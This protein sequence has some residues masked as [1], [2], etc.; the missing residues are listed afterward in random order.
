M[1][2][3]IDPATKTGWCNGFSSGVEDFS[4]KN[5]DM[6]DR[7]IRFREWLEN[8]LIGVSMV[9][10]EKP[11][12]KMHYQPMR[13]HA[14]LECKIIEMCTDRGI[15]WLPVSASEIKKWATGKGN[16]KKEQMIE[17]AQKKWISIEIKSSD[18]ADALFLHDYAVNG[19][20]LKIKQC[21]GQKSWH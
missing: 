10:F 13:V 12:G 7:I 19:G 16:A 17:A 18:E 1:I 8:A 3:A 6:A 9:V 15:G 21:T 5:G 11:V 14:H 2:L 4:V 20:L